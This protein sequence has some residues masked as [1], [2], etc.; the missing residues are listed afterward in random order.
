MGA[1]CM[2]HVRPKSCH[3]QSF[4]STLVGQAVSSRLDLKRL[5][6]NTLYIFELCYVTL[7]PSN[8]LTVFVYLNHEPSNC[9]RVK[10]QGPHSLRL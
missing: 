8:F 2:K 3:V 5:R 6:L 7:Q 10:D 9:P 1:E 4:R